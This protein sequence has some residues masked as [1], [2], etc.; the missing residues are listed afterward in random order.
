MPE[1]NVVPSA[2]NRRSFLAALGRGGAV[3]VA[4]GCGYYSP[5]E[6]AAYEPWRFPGPAADGDRR[7]VHAAILAA[8][9]HNTQPWLFAL[10]VNVIDVYVDEA[11]SL[12]AM[13]PLG[14]ERIIGLGCA[15]ENLV[16]AARHLGRRPT[17]AWLPDP[18]ESDWVARIT[19]EDSEP[20][21]DPLFSSIASRRTNRGRYGAFDLDPRI[22]GE[23]ARLIADER[24]VTLQILTSD[25]DKN[26]FR[27]GTIAATIAIIDDTEMLNDSDAW[28]RHTKDELERFRDG[29]TLDAQALSHWLSGLGKMSDRPSAKDGATYWL[30][31]T[32]DVHT[33]AVSAY[34]LLTTASLDGKED[35][36][37]T[38][39]AYQR[40]HLWLTANGLAAQPLNQLPEC[41]DREVQLGSPTVFGAVLD[42]WSGGRHVQMAFRIGYAWDDVAHSP[43]RAVDDVVE[44]RS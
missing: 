44:V 34:V 11:R 9:P 25:D 36:L 12:G 6:G 24:G 23:L 16:I 33:A 10:G 39:R 19:L 43:R 1:T 35:A 2:L 28:Y 27:D 38:G 42:R 18:T 40:L 29:V 21:P 32:R 15:V 31:N 30:D 8:S 26:A 22:P 41:R 37:A 3:L 20:T 13:D 7:L 4:A 5:G 14:R 17:V